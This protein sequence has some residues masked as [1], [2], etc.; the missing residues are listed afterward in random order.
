VVARMGWY[1]LMAHALRWQLSGITAAASDATERGR[2][3]GELVRRWPPM[4]CILLGDLRSSLRLAPFGA[5]G[6]AGT[7]AHQPG[8]AASDAAGFA[9]SCRPGGDKHSAA[10]VS[11]MPLGVWAFVSELLGALQTSYHRV[12]SGHWAQRR[13]MLQALAEFCACLLRREHDTVPQLP[14]AAGTTDDVR[15]SAAESVLRT[16]L[17]VMQ[18]MLSDWGESAAVDADS[19][20]CYRDAMENLL[21]ALNAALA[22]DLAAITAG[23]SSTSAFQERCHLKAR[24]LL[25]GVSAESSRAATADDHDVATSA[26]GRQAGGNLAHSVFGDAVATAALWA[27]LQRE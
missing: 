13:V 2:L 7:A 6:C 9:Q 24:L 10:G 26:Q 17:T 23:G 14:A 3:A 22:R 5:D 27:A 25:C 12:T 15:A 20:A 8:S 19:A 16:T 11:E 18:E 1:G 21:D 4:A